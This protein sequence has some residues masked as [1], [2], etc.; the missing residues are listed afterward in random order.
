MEFTSEIIEQ[1]KADL[2]DAKTYDDLMGPDGAIMKLMKSAI[3]G[4]LDA[5]LTEHLGYKK[6]SPSGRNTGNSRNG[7]TKKTLKNDNGEI[8]I[9]VPRD[10]NGEFDPVIVKK[11]DR[12]LGPIEDKII[13]III[14]GQKE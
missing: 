3:E 10:R 5:E 13:S 6:H 7:K 2:S 11:Y 4:M 14:I 1:L 9:A 12:T 8:Q